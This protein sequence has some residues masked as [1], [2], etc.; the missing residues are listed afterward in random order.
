MAPT[1][2]EQGAVLPEYLPAQR[3]LEG[4]AL[5]DDPGHGLVRLLA[6][7]P[8]VHVGPA[9]EQQAVDPGQE[10]GGVVRPSRGQDQGQALRLLDG[11]EVVVAERE[12]LGILGVADR[13]PD[14]RPPHIRSGTGMPRRPV[15]TSMW[16]T[17]AST[18]R[19]RKARRSSLAA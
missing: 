17:K 6:V 1:D 9:G 11:P 2:G 13:D 16:R 14:E 3:D 15:S 5:G 18:T 7:E 8:G 19:A 12:E 10:V 4:V